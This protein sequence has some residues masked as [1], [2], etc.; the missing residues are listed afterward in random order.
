MWKAWAVNL[1]RHWNYSFNLER[2]GY[3]QQCVWKHPYFSSVLS[4]LLLTPQLRLRHICVSAENTP[5]LYATSLRI[6]HLLWCWPRQGHHPCVSRRWAWT[7]CETVKGLTATKC[8]RGSHWLPPPHTHPWRHSTCGII[9][10]G[11]QCSRIS[12]KSSN[13]KLLTD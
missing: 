4:L 2:R 7:R 11:A 1:N 12:L 8:P 13:V 6:R 3:C 10:T 5:H 9:W